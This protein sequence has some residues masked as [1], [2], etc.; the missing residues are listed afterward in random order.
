[1]EKIREKIQELVA[2]LIYEHEHYW[3]SILISCLCDLEMHFKLLKDKE[4]LDELII[5]DYI[6]PET[7]DPI[8]YD[9]IPSDSLYCEGC[10]Y[11]SHSNIAK[12]LYGEQSC[13]YCYYLNNGDYRFIRETDLLW[14]SCKC[15]GVKDI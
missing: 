12:F 11:K 4:L 14:D 2:T 7:R 9:N 6:N 15:C 13:G 3:L 10:K 1:M 8:A 5:A